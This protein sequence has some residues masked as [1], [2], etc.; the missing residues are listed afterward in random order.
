MP[1][2]IAVAL[3]P[4]LAD[5][6]ANLFKAA[7]TGTAADIN[8]APSSGADPN[9]GTPLSGYKSLSRNIMSWAEPRCA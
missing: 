4:V 2:L 1:A 5:E 3:R 7:E 8:A 6:D 9:W